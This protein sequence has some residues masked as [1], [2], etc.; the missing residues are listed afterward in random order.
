MKLPWSKKVRFTMDD[1]FLDCFI[2][3][4]LSTTTSWSYQSM[5]QEVQIDFKIKDLQK[6]RR[7][8]YEWLERRI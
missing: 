7:D 3:S 4:I 2:K 6:I 1:Y 5:F 8:I